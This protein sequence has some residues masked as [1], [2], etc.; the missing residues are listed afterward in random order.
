M[1]W[2]RVCDHCGLIYEKY[3]AQQKRLEAT[4]YHLDDAPSGSRLGGLWSA[5]MTPND[6][7]CQ[8]PWVYAVL[9]LTFVAWGFSYM[10]EELSLLGLKGNFLHQIN[11]PFHEAG[12]I[13][14]LPFGD[15]MHSLGGTLGQ[16]LMPVICGIALLW[17]RQDT[18]GASLCLWWFGENFLDI[19]PYIADARAGVL[20]LIGGNIG[21]A[22]PY[23]FHDW[24]FILGETGLLHYDKT[25]GA[26]SLNVGRGIMFAA[27]L[28]GAGLLIRAW[29]GRSS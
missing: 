11:L 19:A 13:V 23:G 7:L 28:W 22:A 1:I 8:F 26:I 10:V 15:F 29:Q 2:D 9:W 16:L 12:H 24:E 6:S 20:P 18:F 17:S 27:M 25:F 4:R 14:F 5:L 21:K 3:E